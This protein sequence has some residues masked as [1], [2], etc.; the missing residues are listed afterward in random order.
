MPVVRWT[1]LDVHNSGASPYTYTFH[2]NPDEMSGPGGSKA[3][4]IARS[5]GPANNPIL[6]EGGMDAPTIDWSGVILEQ[7]HY[8]KFEEWFTRRAMLELEDD[9]GRTFRGVLTSFTPERQR[10]PNRPWYHRYSATF[11]IWA[12]K[13]ASG[14][15]IY[16]RF[17]A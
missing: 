15:E 6:Q 1:F 5:S 8:E 4:N 17:P 12:Y 2:L 14:N 16:G 13:N 3:M 9:L 10:K 11:T 7:E